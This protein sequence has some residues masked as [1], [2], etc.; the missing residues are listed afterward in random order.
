MLTCLPQSIC[1][2]D[3]RV[4][5]APGG[6]AE[7]YFNHWTDQG[8]IVVGRE[9]FEVRKGGLFSDRWT[10][11]H[12]GRGI[13]ETARPNVFFRRFEIEI[14]GLQFT[15]KAVSPLASGFEILQGDR[16]LGAIDRVHIFT[17]RATIEC[18][19]EAPELVQL[20]AFWLVAL[21]WRRQSQHSGAAAATSVH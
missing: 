21:L 8:R 4:P 6:G 3:Y 13:A 7:L 12:G 18:E 1:S 16:R 19:P 17:R 14:N 5:D 9:E 20:F 10:L 2:W 15:L 11:E